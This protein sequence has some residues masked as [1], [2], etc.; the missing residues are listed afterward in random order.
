MRRP[1]HRARARRCSGD[2]RR[3]VAA[4]PRRAARPAADPSVVARST[5]HRGGIPA[6]PAAAPAA[7]GERGRRR[8]PWSRVGPCPHPSRP[9]RPICT[10]RTVTP[11]MGSKAIA[12]SRPAVPRPSTPWN[13]STS[14]RPSPGA[15][16]I[17][18]SSSVRSTLTSEL[19]RGVVWTASTRSVE[20]PIRLRCEGR[21]T[22]APRPWHPAGSSAGAGRPPTGPAS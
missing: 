16:L 18:A 9:R 4:A 13:S 11:G 7:P 10:S 8:R 20:L 19:M 1:R 2:A 15:A 6:R 3:A 12:D 17:D 5:R 22:R 14:R 21:R